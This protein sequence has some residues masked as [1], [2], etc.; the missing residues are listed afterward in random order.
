MLYDHY[1]NRVVFLTHTYIIFT[2]IIEIVS[3]NNFC[4]KYLITVW[5]LATSHITV[6]ALSRRFPFIFN[7]PLM[8]RKMFSIA[9]AGATRRFILI[10][11]S[12]SIWISK[13]GK[14]HK[15]I[16]IVPC[17]KYDIILYCTTIVIIL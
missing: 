13:H 15:H 11:D 9:V 7:Y 16:S 17:A 2:R 3:I 1:L 10:I 6:Y 14:W 12:D 5:Q 4:K 8:H